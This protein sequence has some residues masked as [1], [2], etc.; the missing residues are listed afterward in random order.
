MLALLVGCALR[1]NELAELEIETIRQR[2]GRWVLT[3]LEGKGQR[4]CDYPTRILVGGDSQSSYRL[5][6]I[7]KSSD[8][9]R[10]STLPLS[11]GR[12]TI[13]ID[14]VWMVYGRRRWNRL[15]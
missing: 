8:R 9:F 5:A 2:E 12:F 14:G 6:V 1:R 7:R 11:Q 10:Q 4:I 15:V 13:H 3:D